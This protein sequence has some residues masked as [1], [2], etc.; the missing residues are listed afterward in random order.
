MNL[1]VSESKMNSL[2]FSTEPGEW[3]KQACLQAFFDS[4]EALWE[5]VMKA[6]IKY[7]IENMRVVKAIAAKY[8]HIQDEL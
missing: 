5:N 7:P 6:V 2:E 1:G 8:I 4:G 3:K